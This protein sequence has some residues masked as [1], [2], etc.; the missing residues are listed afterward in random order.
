M[1]TNIF[2]IPVLPL[3]LEDAKKAAILAAK[4]VL[5]VIRCSEHPYDA[6][7]GELLLHEPHL[8]TEFEDHF[9]GALVEDADTVVGEELAEGLGAMSFPLIA[10][11]LKGKV[12]MDVQGAF[13]PQYLRDH[14]RLAFAQNDHVWAR[15]VAFAHERVANER[16][17]EAQERELREAEQKDLQAK[18][19]REESEKRRKEELQKSLE[20]QQKQLREAQAQEAARQKAEE[21]KQS[22]QIK[23]EEVKACALSKLPEPPPADTPAAE[24][25]FIRLVSLNGTACERNFFLSDTVEDLY[26]L[27]ESK[28]EYDGRPFCLFTGFPPMRL[29]RT[30]AA[31]RSVPDLVPRAVVMMRETL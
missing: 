9:L 15:D 28:S 7:F 26:S 1:S 31:I 18:R 6:V 24:V 14:I 30:T 29:E 13:S 12:V 25:A 8:L 21:E 4:Y 11:A 5:L 22:A 23:L 10:V 19:E 3:A 16:I 27:A 17:R 20:E 2:G